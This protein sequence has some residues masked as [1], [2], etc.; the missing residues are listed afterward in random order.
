MKSALGLSLGLVA[1][2]SLFGFAGCGDDDDSNPAV[3][4]T[5]SHAGAGQG[6]SP[7]D[8][9]AIECQVLGELCHEAD[10][11]S[12][13]AH[14]CHEVGHE[15]VGATCLKEFAG[16]VG[17][18]VH[19]EG[20]GGAAADKDP[21]CAALGELCHPVDDKTGPLHDCHEVGH[22]G[23]AAACAAAFDDCATK[24]L[25]AHEALEAGEGGSAGAPMS[26]TGG[27]PA[28]VGGA[29]AATGG[30]STGGAGGAP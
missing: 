4:G 13:P 10:T 27:A 19:E 16:C 11:G 1:V 24:C 5:A 8:D 7:A 18:C 3:G 9:G 21:K 6:G 26:T 17:T 22:E 2:V 30:V 28:A 25:A 23:D 29:P 12:G 20:A 14:D 15:S